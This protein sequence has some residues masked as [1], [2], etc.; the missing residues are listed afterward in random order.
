MLSE[1]MQ[2]AI[3]EQ[4]KNE[5]YSGYLYLSMAAYCETEGLP[6]FA[7]WMR[8]QA[9][10]EKEHAM[11]LFDFVNDRGGRVILHAIE[12]PPVAFGTPLEIFRAVLEHE[13]KVT[14]LIHDLYDLAL[15]EE[16]YASQVM[17]HWFI[18]E[19][20]EEEKSATEIVD[21]LERVRDHVSGL[22]ALDRQL[23]A[24]EED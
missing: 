10:E 9:E 6:G 1:K 13:K 5:L 11:R 3:N 17:L 22:L 12:E 15:Q 8:L 7:Q 4:I 19:Q 18:A 2:A 16:D 14:R 20:V 23:G 21:V 24:R